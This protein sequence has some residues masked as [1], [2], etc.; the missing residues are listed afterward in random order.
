FESLKQKIFPRLVKERT[1][2]DP[3]RIWVLGCS[4]GEE[5]YSLAMAYA[6]FAEAAGTP[7]PLQLFATDLNGAGIEK[8]RA[9]LYPKSIAHD[10]SAERL[11]RFFFE[12]DGHYRVSRVI[13]ERCV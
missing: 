4:T 11:R 9:G 6:E 13:R 8:A 7:V 12:V 5:A 2:K 10:V 1:H 3:L